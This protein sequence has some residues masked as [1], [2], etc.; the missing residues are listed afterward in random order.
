MWKSQIQTAERQVCV[1]VS[2]CVNKDL[3]T[4]H[5]QDAH[6][7]SRV[8]PW[9]CQ[10]NKHAYWP[11][12]GRLLTSDLGDMSTGVKAPECELRFITLSAH[13][14]GV[15]SYH[16]GCVNAHVCR[17]TLRSP[18]IP[19]STATTTW[20]SRTPATLISFEFLCYVLLQSL[21]WLLSSCACWGWSLGTKVRYAQEHRM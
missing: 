14:G 7:Y 6:A 21:L 11:S 15:C 18:T 17:A 2:V 16:T 8:R 13:R 20:I 19:K 9:K 4:T 1:C 12:L 5:A 3:S 10:I